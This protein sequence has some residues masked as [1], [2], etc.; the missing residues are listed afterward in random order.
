M[1]VVLYNNYYYYYNVSCSDLQLVL[2]CLLCICNAKKKNLVQIVFHVS[3][4]WN[5]ILK[6]SR[7]SKMSS[8]KGQQQVEE[9][10]W[11]LYEQLKRRLDR[12]R[13]R[14]Y[15]ARKEYAASTKGNEYLW[16]QRQGVVESMLF[17]T[18]KA[19]RDLQGCATEYHMCVAA[20]KRRWQE[21]Q[22]RLQQLIEKS[23][24]TK[25]LAKLDVVESGKL[26]S[27]KEHD[28][29]MMIRNGRPLPF[30]DNIFAEITELKRVYDQLLIAMNES[31]TEQ[32][33]LDRQH[34]EP[35]EFQRPEQYRKQEAI[36]SQTIA[37]REKAREKLTDVEQGLVAAIKFGEPDTVAKILAEGR[38]NVMTRTG[39]SRETPLHIAALG[40][41]YEIARML[42]EAGAELNADNIDDWTPLHYCCSIM[43]IDETRGL[44][45]TKM[46]SL[47]LEKGANANLGI[48]HGRAE[49]MP[50]GSTSLHFASFSGAIE[51]VKL[52]LQYGAE[53]DAVDKNGRTPIMIAASQNHTEIVELFESINVNMSKRD[54]WCETAHEHVQNMWKRLGRPLSEEHDGQTEHLM[55]ILGA[56]LPQTDIDAGKASHFNILHNDSTGEEERI[57][58]RVE[59]ENL[60][61]L[62]VAYCKCIEFGRPR[63]R[64]Q[65]LLGPERTVLMV[66]WTND[67]PLHT[68]KTPNAPMQS[69][70]Q[71]LQKYLRDALPE[72]VIDSYMYKRGQRYRQYFVNTTIS[73]KNQFMLH[74]YLRKRMEEKF[75]K[76]GLH[77]SFHLN[78]KSMPML[79]MAELDGSEPFEFHGHFDEYGLTMNEKVPHMKKLLRVTS[80]RQD[81]IAVEACPRLSRPVSVNYREW[82]TEQK[83]RLKGAMKAVL[84]TTIMRKV[85][86]GV[87]RAAK[88]VKRHDNH[89][90]EHQEEDFDEGKKSKK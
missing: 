64:L 44:D 87:L 10:P 7:V 73:C 1:L 42:I 30:R 63:M 43:V 17:D 20:E 32:V 25:T 90:E 16:K 55:E 76:H 4:H 84:S 75:P 18:R 67:F 49:E 86:S 78:Y 77:T 8:S 41:H 45:R 56:P 53:K 28:K 24:A 71:V 88:S 65:E 79:G 19:L 68:P 50:D 51:A 33:D 47:L 35:R 70:L 6:I 66:D 11:D 22:E 54:Y 62:H 61:K 46:V 2:S 38:V 48:T 26:V 69:P 60:P 81:V 29:S 3:I 83:Q 58:Y 9:D 57:Y 59:D 85:V 37:Q 80:A 40:G 52:L 23:D 74:L 34:Q 12:L 72:G 39:T 89:D 27:K 82:R 31:A 36:F 13:A 15:T 5:Y 21:D 14:F